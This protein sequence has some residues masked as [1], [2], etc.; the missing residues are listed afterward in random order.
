MRAIARLARPAAAPCAGDRPSQPAPLA[1]SQASAAAPSWSTA[2][3]ALAPTSATLDR[4]DDL[5]LTLLALSPACCKSERAS[6][7]PGSDTSS[8]LTPLS[9][10]IG[11]EFIGVM[12]GLGKS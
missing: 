8:I 10:T 7:C 4:L 3:A 1:P 6:F 2:Y 5:S 11:E 12:H 9:A